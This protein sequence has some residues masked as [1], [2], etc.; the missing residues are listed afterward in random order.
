MS[1]SAR[2]TCFAILLSGMI[3]SAGVV[4]LQ[5]EPAVQIAEDELLDVGI[6][7]LDPG[8]K[9][10]HLLN[11]YEYINSDLRRSEAAFI[12]V[13]VMRT[14]Q[15]TESFGLVRMMPSNSLSADL[16]VTGR[17]RESSGR[18][19]GLELEVVDATGRRWLKRAYKQKARPASYA[20]SFHSNVEPFQEVYQNFADDLVLAQ[21]RMKEEY[22]GVLRQI[23]ELRFA[24]QL[25]PG[26]FGDY[27][28]VDRQGRIELGRLPARD[29]PMLARIRTIRTRDEFFL[30]LLAERYQGFYAAMDKPYDD[31]RAT[32][33]EVEL[34]L[35][36]ARAQANLA[37]AKALFAPPNREFG[38]RDPGLAR[39]DFFRRQ[40]A[41]QAEYLDEIANT[42]TAEVDPLKLELDGEVIRFEG[43]IEDQYR[44]WQELLEKIFETETGMSAGSR[45]F[46]EDFVTRH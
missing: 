4:P 37:N 32:R 17:I 36:D 6:L 16:Y 11:G 34:A 24:A 33:Y 2:A 18:R 41:A 31:F 29:D 25:A 28:T 10:S 40:A 35:R 19:L 27:L 22:L 8:I 26:I 3:G 43:T 45:A 20:F 30:D 38:S 9:K 21:G 13:H 42:F 12:A 14:L 5:A 46:I 44:Q 15:G 1:W 39:A 7:V 23:A